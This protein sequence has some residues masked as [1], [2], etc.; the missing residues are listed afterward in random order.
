[1]IETRFSKLVLLATAKVISRVPGC[2]GSQTCAAA[3]LLASKVPAP[4][5]AATVPASNARRPIPV[6]SLS[7]VSLMS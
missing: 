5:A 7:I 4:A 3:G 1:M 2:S 6:F